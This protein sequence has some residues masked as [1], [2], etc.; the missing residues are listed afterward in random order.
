ME[1]IM[2]SLVVQ[3][4]IITHVMSRVKVQRRE[5]GKKGRRVGTTLTVRFRKRHTQGECCFI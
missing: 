3:T 4:N 1:Q 5:P 2:S